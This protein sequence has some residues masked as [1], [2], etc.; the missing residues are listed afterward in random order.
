[1]KR[2]YLVLYLCIVWALSLVF[3]AAIEGVGGYISGSAIVLVVLCLDEGI[4][5]EIA[6]GS[7]RLGSVV[8]TSLVLVAFVP[9]A[10]LHMAWLHRNE[11]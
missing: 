4:R 5:Q 9:W 1:M 6:D 11:D 7:D 3:L 10:F 2:G 8:I